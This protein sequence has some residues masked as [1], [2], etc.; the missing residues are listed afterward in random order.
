MMTA[1]EECEFLM[2]DLLP[3]VQHLL[4][5]N[6]EFYPAGS[7]MNADVSIEFTTSYDGNEHPA[8]QDVV[9]FLTKAHK[10]LAKQK[11]IKASAIAFNASVIVAGKKTDAIVMRLEHQSGYSITVGLPYTMNLFKKIKYGDMFAQRGSHDIFDS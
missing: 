10:A 5:K 8:S 2:N 7:V 9:N 1:K 11:H 3:S 4:E 6:H